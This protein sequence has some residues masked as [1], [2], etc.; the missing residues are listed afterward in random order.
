MTS[1]QGD[2]AKRD[3]LKGL[4]CPPCPLPDTVLGRGWWEVLLRSCRAPGSLI[5]IG[6]GLP[7]GPARGVTHLG[8]PAV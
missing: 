5:D 2:E 4:P 1:T 6:C 7:V 8:S 3:V